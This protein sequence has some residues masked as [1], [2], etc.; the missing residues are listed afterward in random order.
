MRWSITAASAPVIARTTALT[1]FGASISSIIGKNIK[2]RRTWFG[3]VKRD[4][5]MATTGV[6]K[7]EAEVLG[8]G[9][10]GFSDINE[11]VALPTE[12]LPIHWTQ[13]RKWWICFLAALTA[14]GIGATLMAITVAKGIG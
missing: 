7:Y 10:K 13:T 11:D 12:T 6:M 2:T 1:R 14:L 3:T 5:T 9:G 4:H 8:P